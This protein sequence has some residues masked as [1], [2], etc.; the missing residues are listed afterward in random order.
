PKE[1]GLVFLSLSKTDENRYE[2]ARKLVV[3]ADGQRFNLGET[4]RSKQSQDGLFIETMTAAIPVD[5]F[6]VVSN[7]KQVKLKLGLTVVDLT[8]AQINALR[9]MASYISD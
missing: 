7:A 3:V 4:R 2:V 6:I 5:D 8:S 9:V 1:V